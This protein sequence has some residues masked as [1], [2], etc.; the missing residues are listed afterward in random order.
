MLKRARISDNEIA[1]ASTAA[2]SKFLDILA[3][4]HDIRAFIAGGFPRDAYCRE[5]PKDIDL[6]VQKNQFIDAWRVLFPKAKI[7]NDG[8]IWADPD[9]PAYQHQ[10]IEAQVEYPFSGTGFNISPKLPINLIG[11]KS[12]EWK[13]MDRVDA[14]AE[15][16]IG[17]Y[18]FGICM[19]AITPT[20]MWV[21]DKFLKD[22]QKKTCTLYRSFGREFAVAHYDRIKKK[23]PWPM[24]LS[25]DI[26][27]YDNHIPF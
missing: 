16:V 25:E 4:K 3:E 26:E 17:K 20:G 7:P 12:G 5:Q 15:R 21:N 9:G 22:V 18:D 8:S 1:V 14:V 6:Y 24:V 27:D 2:L 19:A 23:Y 10:S 11:I 13:N